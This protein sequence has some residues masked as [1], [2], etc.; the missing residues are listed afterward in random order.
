[1][2][3]SIFSLLVVI[4]LCF[5]CCS[6]SNPLHDTLNSRLS[7]MTYGEAIQRFGPPSRCAEAGEILVCDWIEEGRGAVM[8]P[9]G[10]MTAAIPMRGSCTRLTFTNGVLTAWQIL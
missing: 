3:K 10:G 7:K 1:M 8:M 4:Y 5:G 6:T 2:K 9:V